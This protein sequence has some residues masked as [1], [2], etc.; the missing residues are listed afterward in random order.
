MAYIDNL[1]NFYQKPA[2]SQNGPDI[3]MQGQ[4]FWIFLVGA[5]LR[6]KGVLTITS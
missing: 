4:V 2:F 5:L 3:W 6:G 1:D